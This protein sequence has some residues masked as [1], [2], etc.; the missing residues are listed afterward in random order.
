MIRQTLTLLEFY[1]QVYFPARL[2]RRSKATDTQMR[3]TIKRLEQ[4]AGRKLNISEICEE[5][6]DGF[7]VWR[8]CSGATVNKDLRHVRALCNLAVR[9]RHRA[10]QLYLDFEPVVEDEPEAWSFAEVS[11]IL[12]SCRQEKGSICEIPADDWWTAQQLTI[13]NVGSRI[14]ATMKTPVAKYDRS[15]GTLRIQGRN[16]KQKKGQVEVLHE[17]VV[18]A[19]D[20]I[21]LGFPPRELLFPWPYDQNVDQW[22]A[23]NNAYR[24][25][26]ARAGLPT[27]DK[28]LFHKM[29]RTNATYVT[30][31][32]DEETAKKQLGHSTVAVTQRY[33]D[34]AKLPAR[35]TATD[36]LPWDLLA[37]KR[38]TDRQLRLFD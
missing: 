11:R 35:K 34:K 3:L 23:L 15:T 30:A 28:D 25:I 13:L 37:I 19:L 31:A 17:T 7:K 32:A 12:A 10:D 29:R 33:I 1:E 5:M 4:Y 9:R 38:D 6:L 8:K 18:A 22:P 14:T 20:R 36:L 26:L 21:L 24:R 27:T 16:Q 2:A